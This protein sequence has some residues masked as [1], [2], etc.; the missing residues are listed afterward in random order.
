MAPFSPLPFSRQSSFWRLGQAG[1]PRRK[2]SEAEFPKGTKRS[3][4]SVAGHQPGPAPNRTKRFSTVLP[5]P[6]PR[7]LRAKR[8]KPVHC[9]A[10]HCVAVFCSFFFLPFL[11]FTSF[12]RLFTSFLRLFTSFLRLFTSF[13]LILRGPTLKLPFF[14]F[15]HSR[16]LFSLISPPIFP[17]F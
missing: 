3:V 9:A 2:R 5:S 8:A 15:F 11:D 16:W 17:F 13:L 14:Y 12:L 1:G 6:P 4:A 10:V 7:I